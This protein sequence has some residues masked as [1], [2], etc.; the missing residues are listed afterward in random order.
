MAGSLNKVMIIG[1]LG[2]D[3][4]VRS[5]NSGDEVCNLSIATSEGWNDKASG[6]RK[7]RTQWHKV[8]IFNP[9]LVKVAKSYLKKGSKVYIEGQIETRKWADKEGKDQYTTEI[10][11]RPYRS[12]LTMLDSK[13]GSAANDGGYSEGASSGGGYGQSY[14][15]GNAA[16][17][18]RAD[19]MADDIPF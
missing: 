5:M 15:G 1:N 3:P 12:E 2:A 14:G 16:P 13:G 4:D 7:E 8:V 10:V 19:E 11:L 9:A 6:E 17:A 18:A